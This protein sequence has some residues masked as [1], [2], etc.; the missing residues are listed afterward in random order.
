MLD[1]LRHCVEIHLWLKQL[2]KVTQ[3]LL[4]GPEGAQ[5]HTQYKILP[6]TSKAAEKMSSTIYTY[7]AVTHYGQLS[8]MFHFCRLNPAPK[9]DLS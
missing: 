6:K 5:S 2:T 8:R 3:K 4:K 7:L 9:E 1:I